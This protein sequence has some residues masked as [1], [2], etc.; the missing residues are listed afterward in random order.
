VAS[1]SLPFLFAVFDPALILIP[2]VSRKTFP[3]SFKLRAFVG[4]LLW[5]RM[6]CLKPSSK[7]Y[8]HSFP[9][10]TAR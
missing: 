4:G 2:S 10:L 9:A 3:S 5:T 8:K 1:G 6:K 7:F